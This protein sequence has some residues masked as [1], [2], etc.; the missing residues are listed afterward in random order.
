MASK[1]SLKK[2]LQTLKEDMILECMIYK[3]FH[4]KRKISDIS[5]VIDNIEIKY[6][7]L[8]K[9]INNPIKTSDKKESKKYY[10]DIINEIKTDFVTILDG[11][12]K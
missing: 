11:L 3:D 6:S 5:K 2:E 9:R 1:K 10:K 4:P 7:D 8:V 12:E